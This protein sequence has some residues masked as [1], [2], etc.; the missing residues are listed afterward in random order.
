[1]VFWVWV[2][3]WVSAVY[4]ILVFGVWLVKI[5]LWSGVDGGGCFLLSYSLTWLGPAWPWLPGKR[6]KLGW[7]RWA[8]IFLCQFTPFGLDVKIDTRVRNR[9]NLGGLPRVN[10]CFLYMSVI[11]SKIET[12]GEWILPTFLF[13]YYIFRRWQFITYIFFIFL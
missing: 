8:K 12:V 7:E 6:E 3:V 1:M 11:K 4:G 13:F 5:D 10:T 2:W 9:T